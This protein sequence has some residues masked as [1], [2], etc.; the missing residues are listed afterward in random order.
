MVAINES[1]LSLKFVGFIK[2][3]ISKLSFIFLYKPVRIIK[4]VIVIS[5]S[6]D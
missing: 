6:V 3:L 1:G 2:F 5:I 4:I